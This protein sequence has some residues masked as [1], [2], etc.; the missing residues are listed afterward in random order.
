MRI[1]PLF[2]LASL[3]MLLS[4]T[5]SKKEQADL[6][7]Q[8]ATI[9]TVDEQ[10]SVANSLVIKNGKFLAVGDQKVIREK[11]EA[12]KTVDL[13]GKYV[14][15]GFID[16]H[17]HFYGYA[18]N[19]RQVNLV[20]THSFDEIIE[21]LKEYH[22]ANDPEWI[23]GRGWDQNDWPVREFPDKRKLDHAFPE[24]PVF[25]K[26]IDGHAAIVNSKALEIAGINSN[27]SVKGG[28][29]IMESGE[30]TGVLI[31][32]ASSLVSEKIP[33]P[34]LEEKTHALR[35]GAE[36]CFAVGLTSV[37]D[38]G[39][40]YSSIQLMDSLQR[41]GD[42]KMQTN[43]MLSPTEKNFNQYMRKGIY[44]TERMHINSIKLYADG[45]LGSRGA[46][47][48]EPY[49]DA[50]GNVG[51]MVTPRKKLKEYAQ[52]A[53]RNN[54]QVNTHAI[55]DSANRTVLNIYSEI[56]KKENDRRWRIEH[57]Q[58]IHPDDY[59]LFGQYNIVPAINTTHATSDMFW[60]DERLGEERLKH[61]YA[62]KKLLDQ[63]GWIPNGSDFPV[64]DINPMYGFYAG[65]TR[66][67]LEGKPEEG[68]QTENALSRKEALKAMTIWAA[69]SF[70]EEDMKGSIEPGKK[71]DFVVTDRDI[72]KVDENLLPET[73]VLQTYIRGEKVYDHS[74]NT[75]PAE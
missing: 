65:V 25:L 72:M 6:I 53:Y 16:A 10:F 38:A 36:N 70:F 34:T 29:I 41:S 47:L 48:L 14:Y 20:G 8:N 51:F 62:Y 7:V 24:T 64:E 26:R 68:F 9:Y 54:Y 33:E 55:G 22:Q 21:K 4:C 5:G 13:K 56:L 42:L 19:L 39:L 18:M 66:K 30:P 2:F 35:K 31:D 49:A 17:C 28:K 67:N 15:P 45:A 44:Q 63:N 75:S 11:Y 61:A 46:C 73:R 57:A 74:N 58:V 32:N 27:R 1:S 59:D 40:P 43:V 23:V 3:I 52:M 50:P 12:D 37:F 60:A 71:A 69:K